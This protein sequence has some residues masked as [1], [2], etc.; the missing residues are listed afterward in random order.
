[1]SPILPDPKPSD[2]KPILSKEVKQLDFVA[3]GKFYEV[4]YQLGPNRSY[5]KSFGTNKWINDVNVPLGEKPRPLPVYAV[6]SRIIDGNQA[7]GLISHNNIWREKN[8]RGYNPTDPM[9]ALQHMLAVIEVKELKDYVPDTMSTMSGAF[10]YELF[11]AMV[12]REVALATKNQ[13]PAA[14]GGSKG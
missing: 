6:F 4:T 11:Q 5:A 12:A 7:N 2:H 9:G 8:L 13:Q 1:M 3:P 14:V 10:S